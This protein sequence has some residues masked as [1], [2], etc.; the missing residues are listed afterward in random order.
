[1]EAKARQDR[2]QRDASD[3]APL[4]RAERF[5]IATAV[6]L[7]ITVVATGLQMLYPG[8]L[9][10][11]RRNPDALKAGEWWRMVT[12]L[13][14]HS[15]GWLQIITNL[16]GIAVVGALVERLFGSWRWLALYFVSGLIA[17]AISYAWEPYGAGASIALCGLIGGLLVWLWNYNQ[18]ARTWQSLYVV[19]L[20]AGLVGYAIGGLT[21]D[22]I[23]AVSFGSLFGVL[24]RR[25][26]S[27]RQ[28]SRLLASAGLA[29]AVV[30]TLLRDNHGPGLLAGAG[31]ATLLLND[32]WR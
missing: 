9:A 19:Y 3:S 29:G 6:V 27:E 1:V 28:L 20:I 10:A 26:G 18:P 17:E 16:V 15:D 4:A 2:S 8:V 31:L 30:L 21:A 13:F 14:V 7:A 24:M 11:L 23:L 32:A 25:P 22:I 5:P 12:P